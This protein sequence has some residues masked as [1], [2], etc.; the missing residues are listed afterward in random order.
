MWDYNSPYFSFPFLASAGAY[1][2]K[3]TESGYDVRNIGVD[4]SGAVKGLKAIIDLINQGVLPRGSTQSVMDE[5]M[6]SGVLATMVNGPWVWA[7]LHKVASISTCTAFRGRRQSGQ[8]VR[9]VITALI[10]RSA[11]RR[12]RKGVSREI[13]LHG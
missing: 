6:S 5:K 1:P 12:L 10:N 2:F 13:R 4:N 7:D 9:R 11:E 3:R 8:A